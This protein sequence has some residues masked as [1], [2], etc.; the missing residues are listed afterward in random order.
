M[1]V[2]LIDDDPI[3]LRMLAITVGRLGLATEA[4]RS[5]SAGLAWLAEHP[6]C[7][8]VVTDLTMPGLSGLDV[9]TAING[10]P[11]W[12]GLEVILCTGAADTETVREAISLGVRHYIVKPIKPS[13]LAPKVTELLRAPATAPAAASPMEPAAAPAGEPP[14]VVPVTAPDVAAPLTLDAE[15]FSDRAPDDEA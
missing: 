1:T 11:R 3:S 2:L 7:D 5:G 9:F 13:I 15:T 12:P 8:L 14:A 6:D 10:D 4:F